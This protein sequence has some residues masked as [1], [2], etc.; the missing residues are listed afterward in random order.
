MGKIDWSMPCGGDRESRADFQPWPGAYAFL[1]GARFQAWK[2]RARTVGDPAPAH[3]RVI[4]R[5]TVC[6]LPRGLGGIARSSTGRK[7][8]YAGGGV[9]EWIPSKRRRGAGMNLPAGFRY[10]SAYAGL[11][12]V[13]KNDLS[14]I[15]SDTPASAAA[16]FTEE[17][18]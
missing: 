10:A 15:V 12:K 5:K 18:R 17:S 16:V 8:A 11:R 13:A 14:L 3:L 4:D 6:G 1:N 9:P 2:A 7:E